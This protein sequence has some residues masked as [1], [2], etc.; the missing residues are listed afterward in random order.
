MSAK[1]TPEGKVELRGNVIEYAEKLFDEKEY[2]GA[3]SRILSLIQ[4]WMQILYD[5]HFKLTYDSFEKYRRSERKFSYF[6]L[7]S[8]LAGIK[9]INED[10]KKRLKDFRESWSLLRNRLVRHTYSRNPWYAVDKKEL[11]AAFQNG[12]DLVDFLARKSN[13]HVPRAS[14]E[15]RIS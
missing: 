8:D 9:L 2:Y 4:C 13:Y 12:K 1:E 7:I 10:E 6:I 15:A 14:N 3:F 11:L 5:E